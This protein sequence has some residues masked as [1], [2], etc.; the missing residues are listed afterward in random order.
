MVLSRQHV[1]AAGAAAAAT[2]AAV[3][4]AHV[5]SRRRGRKGKIDRSR[6]FVIV[7]ARAGSK[8][9]KGKNIKEFQGKPLMAWAIENGLRSRYVSRVFVST[10]S[11]EYRQV[12][13]SCGAEAPFLRP[14]EIAHDTATDY[15][16]FDHFLRWM[17]ANDTLPSLL[18]QLRPTAPC[19]TVETVDACIEEFLAHED[20][21]YDS[22]R[23]VTPID[24]EAY[25][26]YKL[27]PHEPAHL[28]PLVPETHHKDDPSVRIKE[29]QSV[30]RQILPKLFWHNAYVD[31]IRP[32]AILEQGC[33][34][35]RKCLAF[36][37][38]PDDTQDIDTPEQ[39]AD[40][41]RKKAQQLA[42]ASR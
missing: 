40:A 35:G 20:E 29:P 26:M 15:E 24:H 34:M 14:K 28:C 7:P 6:I 3:L 36:H 27:D 25:N 9:V 4:G 31:I 13:L 16:C 22:L 1:L 32:E 19:L 38:S 8:G 33:C 39:W 41:E 42:Q 30:A 10:D 2:V 5:L 18:V 12:A 11:E 17:Q 23:T 37:M 21:G